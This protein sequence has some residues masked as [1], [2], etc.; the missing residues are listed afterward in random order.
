MGSLV[1]LHLHTITH[2]GLSLCL[3]ISLRAC[4]SGHLCVLCMCVS[5]SCQRNQRRRWTWGFFLGMCTFAAQ[6]APWVNSNWAPGYAERPP[7]QPP[8]PPHKGG[9]DSRC[10]ILQ[11]RSLLRE[12]PAGRRAGGQVLKT[13]SPF[14]PPTPSPAAHAVGSDN[15]T[16]TSAHAH[17][18]P[19][20]PRCAGCEVF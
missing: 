16:L 4:A 10:T 12:G 11:L 2:V 9:H 13:A 6:I 18:C 15:S 5:C 20:L 17:E 8:I 1:T 7:R 3:C 19:T 14:Y